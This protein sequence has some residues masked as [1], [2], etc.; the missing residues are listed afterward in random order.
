MSAPSAGSSSSSVRPLPNIRK[1]PLFKYGALVF[2]FAGIAWLALAEGEQRK[3]LTILY[4]NNSNGILRHCGCPGNP[5]GSLSQ[6]FAAVEEVRR[7]GI[8]TLLLDA[9]DLFPDRV[10]DDLKL[11]YFLKILERFHYDAIV[12]GDQEFVKGVGFAKELIES[13]RFPFLAANLFDAKLKQPMAQ[14]AI[15]KVVGGVSC[16][17]IGVIAPSAFMFA[18][19]EIKE[20]LTFRDPVP[21]VKEFVKKEGKDA[22]LIIVLSHLGEEEDRKLAEAVRGIHVIVGGHT[23]TK[24]AQPLRVNKTLI[25]QAGRNGEYLGTLE[26]EFDQG[27]IVAWS[28]RL[29]SLDPDSKG[30]AEIEKIVNEYESTAKQVDLVSG[31]R[32]K[33]YESARCSICHRSA[34][35]T[36]LGSKH[37]V[38]L[39]SLHEDPRKKTMACLMCH[40]TVVGKI[41]AG[42]RKGVPKVVGDVQCMACHQVIF[43]KGETMHIRPVPDVRKDYCLKCHDQI[44]SPE[45][46]YAKY[47][48]RIKHGK[49]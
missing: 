48:A 34:H 32:A 29:I 24:L 43:P 37:H 9:G 25:V 26:L 12:L 8:P 11:T 22:D 21:V 44:N 40:G 39:K 38:A 35:T 17:I 23:Q 36:W 27:E 14:A 28:G 4:T 10:D 3:K 45:F 47:W 33:P 2:V 19:E 1:S 20:R 46:D 16:A 41:V 6:R 18:P 13:K 49:E 7:R 31:D 15:K 30:N 42:P 5:Q